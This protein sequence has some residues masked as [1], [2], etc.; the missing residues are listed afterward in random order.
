MEKEAAAL[1]DRFDL[2][3]GVS[4]RQLRL[5]EAR[6]SVQRGLTLKVGARLSEGAFRVEKSF[7]LVTM[8]ES[9]IPQGQKVTS[10]RSLSSTARACA[11]GWGGGWGSHLW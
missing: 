10:S 1:A 4:D 11:G 3:P 2:M 8:F 6:K 9:S 5:I 7:F